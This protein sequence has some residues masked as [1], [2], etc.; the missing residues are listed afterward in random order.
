[1]DEDVLQNNSYFF[2][3]AGWPSRSLDMLT[4]SSAPPRALHH[5]HI[6]LHIMMRSRGSC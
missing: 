2:V 6:V 5:R 1:M 4:F 3:S